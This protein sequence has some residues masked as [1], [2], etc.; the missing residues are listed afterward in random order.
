MHASLIARLKSERSGLHFL[1]HKL[2]DIAHS[3]VVMVLTRF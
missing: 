2:S 3:S 1:K